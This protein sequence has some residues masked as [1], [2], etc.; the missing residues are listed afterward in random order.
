M[1]GHTE[2]KV[3]PHIPGNAAQRPRPTDP[4]AAACKR[5][6]PSRERCLSGP[7]EDLRD[8]AGH[9]PDSRA[10]PR[11]SRCE[12]LRAA[13]PEAWASSLFQQ[14]HLQPPARHA[15]LQPSW[16]SRPAPQCCPEGGAPGSTLST[17]APSHP[18]TCRTGEHTTAAPS[19][20]WVRGRQGSRGREMAAGL[21]VS[22]Q[23]P[24]DFL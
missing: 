4:E 15:L 16:G 1:S 17:E 2:V 9:E 21:P 6:C 13:D 8:K 19:S 11:S 7:G 3:N 23:G 12:S 14:A 10:V 22:L 24:R 20:P 18:D 5:H